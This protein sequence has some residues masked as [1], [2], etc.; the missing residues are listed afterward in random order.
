LWL[1]DGSHRADLAP[2]PEGPR[3]VSGQSLAAIL[4]LDD[5]PGLV[6]QRG[7]LDTDVQLAPWPDSPTPRCMGHNGKIMP[8]PGPNDQDGNRVTRRPEVRAQADVVDDP[9]RGLMWQKG[10]SPAPLRGIA[11]A[12]YCDALGFYGVSDWRLPRYHEIIGIVDHGRT[13]PS[14]LAA[15]DG[16]KEGILWTATLDAGVPWVLTAEDGTLHS[17]HY[18]DP[19]PW[20]SHFARCVRGDGGPTAR[21]GLPIHRYRRGPSTVTDTLQ[22]IEW[23]RA[24][25]KEKLSWK[26]ALEYCDSLALAD[27]DDYRLPS[28]RE[29]LSLAQWYDADD[30]SPVCKDDGWI[31]WADDAGDNLWTSTPSPDTE[32]AAFTTSGPCAPGHWTEPVAGPSWHSE[33]PPRYHALCVRDAPAPHVAQPKAI[34]PH[35][36]VCLPVTEGGERCL[37]DTTPH[38]PTVLRYPSGQAYAAGEHRDGKRE[39]VWTTYHDFGPVWFRTTYSAGVLEGE[40]VV[41]YENG[42]KRRQGR[43]AAGKPEGPW[44]EWEPSG[45]EQRTL[46]YK[47]GLREGPSTTTKNAVPEAHETFASGLLDGTW[48]IHEEGRP[49]LTKRFVGGVAHG[50]ATGYHENGGQRFQ[51]SYENGLPEGAW[52]RFHP[53]GEKSEELG[54]HAGKPTGPLRGYFPDGK[55]SEE[56]AHLDGQKHGLWRAFHPDGTRREEGQ[57]ERGTGTLRRYFKTGVLAWSGSYR[58]GEQDGLLIWYHENGKKQSEVTFRAGQFHGPSR[59]WSVQGTL[60]SEVTYENDKKQGIER[61]WHDDGKLQVERSFDHGRPT[62]T[63]RRYNENGLLHE[64][65]AYEDGLLQGTVVFYIDGKKAIE[66]YYHRGVE[67][68]DRQFFQ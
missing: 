45:D 32:G 13:G 66:S 17:T 63:F 20:G 34:C 53:T 39:G 54:Y 14:L 23:P 5:L 58:D 36:T 7:P 51:G 21:A 29:M 9:D 44:T 10:H 11:A 50:P 2:D 19:G 18:D 35:G 26:D 15:F 60:T 67:V 65:G 30:E 4:P 43:N 56:G 8:C 68:K 3:T 6:R 59:E 52:V 22:G 38:G 46:V 57:F 28:V 40:E 48:T 16:P 33:G 49:W 41:Y 64:E 42:V 25:S 55:L 24:T 27:N 31:A 12:A 37:R 1:A 47:D 61:E 62:G